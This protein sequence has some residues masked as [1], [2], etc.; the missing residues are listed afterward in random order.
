[1]APWLL[2]S[3]GYRHPNQAARRSLLLW[4]PTDPFSFFFLIFS[5]HSF[6]LTRGV[7]FSLLSKHKISQSLLNNL[8]FL[9]ILEGFFLVFAATGFS[10][11][12]ISPELSQLKQILQRLR[13]PKTGPLS[14]H[15]FYSAKDALRRTL[16]HALISSYASGRNQGE[17][18][19]CLGCIVFL[20]FPIPSRS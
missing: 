2:I 7:L 17:L 12:F 10:V 13:S 5:F 18:G 3:S 6:S 8:F 11:S 19:G 16:F 9:F 4:P 15:F 14:F 20:H 1:M